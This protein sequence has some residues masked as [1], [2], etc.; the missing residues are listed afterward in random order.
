ML[1]ELSLYDCMGIEYHVI[2]VFY[3]TSII[4]FLNH[5]FRTSIFQHKN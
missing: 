2:V 4:K 3:N 5:I 1:V